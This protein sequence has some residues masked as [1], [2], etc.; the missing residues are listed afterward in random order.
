MPVLE[1]SKGTYNLLMLQTTR[2]TLGIQRKAV[3]QFE[4]IK[5][6]HDGASHLFTFLP[7]SLGSNW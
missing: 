1:D 3:P 4:P 6:E 2:G 7:N 5:V